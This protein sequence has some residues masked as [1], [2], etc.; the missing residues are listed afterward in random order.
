MAEK[1]NEEPSPEG[2]G[3]S[4]RS[5]VVPVCPYCRGNLDPGK[6]FVFCESCDFRYPCCGGEHSFDFVQVEIDTDKKQQRDIYD[7][8][9]P[10][11]ITL[12]Y[13]DEQEHRRRL[14]EHF[15]RLAKGLPLDVSFRAAMNLRILGHA[16]LRP[17]MEVLDIG[18]GNGELLNT[19]AWHFR[20]RGTGIDLSHL[21]VSRALERNP[22]DL[23]YHIADAEQIPLPDA[24]F[25]AV[26]S[27]DVLEHLPHQEE[28][29][30]EACRLVK[31]GGRI[32]LYAIS[33]ADTYTWHW[34]QRRVSKGFAG[35]DDGGGHRRELFL[36]PGVTADWVRKMDFEEVEVVPFHAFFTL[37][38][39][40]RLTVLL[41]LLSR[42]AFFFTSLFHLC[43]IADTP[44]TDCGRGNGFYLL[45]R[46]RGGR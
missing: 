22:F 15:R 33:T 30:A 39:D 4:L 3:V 35:V 5:E 13:R 29:V 42:S 19:M 11:K 26:V 12:S 34:T 43:R 32:I 36:D 23:A 31:P 6:G 8:I 24:S 27:F 7:G 38:A 28:A 46:R 10:A 44:F 2:V 25:D 1:V 45:G 16:G 9:E 41:P 17:G 14:D 37:L 40:E 20:T 21:A 18:C